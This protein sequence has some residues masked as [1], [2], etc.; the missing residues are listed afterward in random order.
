MVEPVLLNGAGAKTRWANLG[1]WREAR[2]YPSAAAELARR[3]GRAANLGPGDVV[4]DLACGY[5]DSCA[6]WV[7]EFGVARVIGVE[8][9]PAVVVEATARVRGWQL[10]DRI[11]LRRERA[12]FVRPATDAPGVTAVVCVDA[13]YHFHTRELWLRTLK[14]EVAAGTR[15]GLADLVVTHRGRRGRLADLLGRHADI[16]LSN[17]WTAEEIEPSLSEYGWRVE[18]LVR[19][20]PEVLG[21]FVRHARRAGVRWLASPRR[22]GWHALGTAAMIALAGVERRVDY[23]IVA[24]RATGRM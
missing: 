23:A 7:R 4:L 14:R 6:L 2:D 10:A 3:V 15:L 12:E 16:P 5:A 24:A 8:P 1:F 9:D 18:R 17:L 13:A 11:V 21:G 22:G 19:C 20:G